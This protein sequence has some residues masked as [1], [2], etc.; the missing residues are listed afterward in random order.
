MITFEYKGKIYKPSNIE[1]KLK[2]LGC[3]LADVTILEDTKSKDDLINTD[4]TYCQQNDIETYF[5]KNQTEPNNVYVSSVSE[6]Y[7]NNVFNGNFNYVGS[8]RNPETQQIETILTTE[9]RLG[10]TYESLLDAQMRRHFICY[11]PIEENVWKDFDCTMF[12][13]NKQ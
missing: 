12:D 1:N 9:E 11:T 7:L 5:Y 4:L 13:K 2:K 10:I 3:T 8:T 6:P